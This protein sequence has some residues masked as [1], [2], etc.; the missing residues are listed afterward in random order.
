MTPSGLIDPTFIQMND[1]PLFQS[2]QSGD[3]H[4]FPVGRVL[5]SGSHSL[6]DTARGFTGQHQ[7]IW[8]TNT[9]YLDTTRIHRK[10]NGA[11]YNFCELHDG[12]FICSGLATQ[13][14]GYAV[15]RIFRVDANG[16]VDTTFHS[17]VYTGRAFTFVP[18]ADGRVYAGGNF[19]RNMAPMDTLRVVRFLPDG[20][21]DPT[22]TMP[23]FDQGILDFADGPTIGKIT[24]YRDGKSFVMGNFQFV[25][26]EPRRGICVIGS[27]GALTDLFDDCGVGPFTYFG[28]TTANL[29]GILPYGEEDW[30]VWGTY[31]GYDDGAINDPTQRFVS[32]LLGGDLTTSTTAVPTA[33]AATLRIAPNPASTSTTFTYTLKQVPQHAW[34]SI[35]DLAGRPVQQIRIV[36]REGSFS[37]AAPQL[38][39]G[40]YLVHLTENGAAQASV[41]LVVQP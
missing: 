18:L 34:L 4:V 20:T 29:R 39:A 2:L 28:L 5:M 8:F 27:S 40:V 12:K 33:A 35:T 16:A 7:L 21:L 14:D 32:R 36:D 23:H 11:V 13:F 24:P 41:R 3:Y 10:G 25:N 6:Y 37:W 22:F 15:D 19:K 31:N 17:D 26:G 1:D 38:P 30:I 9:G